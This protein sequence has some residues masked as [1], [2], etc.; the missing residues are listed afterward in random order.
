MH[1]RSRVWFPPPHVTSQS[2]QGPQS[3]QTP[4]TIIQANE[5]VVYVI[6]MVKIIFIFLYFLWISGKE[7]LFAWT[8]VIVAGSVVLKRAVASTSAIERSDT[9][10]GSALLSWSTGQWA[11]CPSR[12]F[13][14]NTVHYAKSTWYYVVLFLRIYNVKVF[15]KRSM[16]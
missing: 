5:K 15:K 11:V 6:M 4:S 14:E 1:V 3:S 9:Y 7:K 12:P 8:M 16:L 2:F 10:T 13:H